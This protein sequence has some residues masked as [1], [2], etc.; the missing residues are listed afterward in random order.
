MTSHSNKS[1]ASPQF[2]DGTDGPEQYPEVLPHLKEGAPILL[3]MDLKVSFHLS[4]AQQP[5]GFFLEFC[6]KPNVLRDSG[7]HCSSD[8]LMERW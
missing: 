7:P 6:A 4:N 1:P 2:S 3:K 5:P 8:G